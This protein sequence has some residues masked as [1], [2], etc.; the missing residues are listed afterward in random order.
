MA[1]DSKGNVYVLERGGHALRVVHPN[2]KIYAVATTN[3]ANRMGW[4]NRPA[5]RWHICGPPD[6]VYI[7]DEAQLDPV[8]LQTDEV[9]TVLGLVGR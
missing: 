4:A 1:P 5:W 2:G 9:S 7:A 6:N 8:D 3:A